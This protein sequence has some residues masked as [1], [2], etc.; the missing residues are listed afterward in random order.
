[1]GTHEPP[2]QKQSRPCV[3]GPA[4]R[5]AGCDNPSLL[6]GQRLENLLQL[7][8]SADLLFGEDHFAV[9]G[10]YEVAS[11]PGNQLR[12]NAKPLLQISRQTGGFV[13]VASFGAV[14]DL[15]GH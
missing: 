1:L 5:D 7:G 15:Y 9:H 6:F 13:F 8:E 12:L 14:Q 10:D 2:F 4:T 11:A 3:A